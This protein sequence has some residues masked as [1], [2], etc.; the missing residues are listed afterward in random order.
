[1]TKLY[2]HQKEVKSIFSLL[3]T[4]ENDI[5][6]SLGW[7]LKSIKP[8][9]KK[10]IEEITTTK[11]KLDEVDIF[12]QEF[13]EDRGFTDIE[14][15]SEDLFCII[16]AKVGWNLPTKEQLLRYVDRFKEYPNIQHKL[17]VISEC[18]KS[19]AKNVLDEYGIDIPVDFISWRTVHQ[20]TKDSTSKCSYKG[21]ELLRQLDS[22]FSRVITMQDKDTNEVF[23]VVVSD[24]VQHNDFSF[25]DV[26]K[27][28]YYF[29]PIRGGWPKIP[30]TYIAFR[31]RGKLYSLHYV[32]SYDQITKPDDY[33]PE[34]KGWG[35]FEGPHYILKLGPNFAPTH[36]VK[37]GNIYAS[38][39]IRFMLDTIF[40]SKTIQE[41][42]D[43]SNK[44]KE[45]E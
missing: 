20:W 45:N 21:K 13:G 34:L 27:K 10:F 26:V 33:V 39:H 35:E 9:L 4:K 8:F 28:G 25:L 30:P 19:Y 11:V 24:E 15:F 2:L 32:E 23:C 29:Y 5:T 37:N 3:G 7:C 43:I 14:I 18:K 31:H 38:Q 22:Y 16:E 44:R 17:L 42:R 1:M 6:F 36:E 12:L 41:A 40:T